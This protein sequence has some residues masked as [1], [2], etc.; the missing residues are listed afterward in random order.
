M[1]FSSGIH[2]HSLSNTHTHT[3]TG[4][5]RSDPWVDVNLSASLSGAGV[6]DSSGRGQPDNPGARWERV[7]GPTRSQRATSPQGTTSKPIMFLESI[8]FL[9]L[10]SA[11]MCVLFACPWVSLGGPVLQSGST[12]SHVLKG[13]FWYCSLAEDKPKRTIFI[14]GPIGPFLCSQTLPHECISHYFWII[15]GL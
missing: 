10:N 2:T 15:I 12:L 11:L 6:R 1:L 8:F 3:H 9:L 4:H 7:D 14:D 5:L 13:H